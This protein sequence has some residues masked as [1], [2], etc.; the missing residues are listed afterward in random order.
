M[1][2]E[3]KTKAE[4]LQELDTLRCR[5]A[6]LE[7]AERKKIAEKLEESEQTFRTIFDNAADGIV[8]ADVENKKFYIANKMFCQLLGYNSQEI[9]NLGVLSIH[10]EEDLPYVLEQ[11][12]KQVRREFTLAKNIPVRRKD[13]RVFYADIN[14]TARHSYISTGIH[15]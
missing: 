15:V 4:L 6:Q 7:Q 1:R 14:T 2:D 5:V 12:E 11:F 8:L 3:Q 9:K 10:P 13:G